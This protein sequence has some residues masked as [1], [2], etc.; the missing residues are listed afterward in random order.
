MFSI[1]PYPSPKGCQMK[2]KKITFDHNHS[3]GCAAKEARD[4]CVCVGMVDVV[5]EWGRF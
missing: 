5:D 3:C 2:K 4:V 1:S